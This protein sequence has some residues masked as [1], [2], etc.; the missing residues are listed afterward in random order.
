MIAKS[1]NEVLL[2]ELI[3]QNHI[4]QIVFGIGIARRKCQ[5]YCYILE[6]SYEI[7]IATILRLNHK[8]CMQISIETILGENFIFA[9]IDIEIEIAEIFFDY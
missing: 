4:L 7:N 3:L 8:Y 2:L 1:L 6:K 9:E 5:K